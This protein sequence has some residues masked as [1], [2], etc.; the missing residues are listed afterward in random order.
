MTAQEF[1][2]FWELTYP[3]TYPIGFT[4]RHQLHDRWFR[5]HSLPESK[6]YATEAEE[7]AILLNRQNALLT[8][9]LNEG[10]PMLLI[11]GKYIIESFEDLNPIEEEANLKEFQFTSAGQVD[12]HQHVPQYYDEGQI[13]IPRYSEQQWQ[14]HRFDKVLMD[15]ADGKYSAFFVSIQNQCIVSPYDGGV[16]V[17][18]KDASTMEF[19]KFKY[20][21]WLSDRE[22]GL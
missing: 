17:I 18:L 16:D 6:R 9:L 21:A 20:K 3:G 19:Y 12:L 8:D 13:C 11:T 4:F 15:V 14:P 22:D 2:S 5:I 10:G 7:W 1:L